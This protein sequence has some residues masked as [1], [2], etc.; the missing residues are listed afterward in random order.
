MSD[1]LN[2]YHREPAMEGIGPYLRYGL[3][4]QGCH[5]NCEGCMFLENYD[6]HRENY[7]SVDDLFEEIMS[8]KDIDGITVSGGE[9]LLQIPALTQLFKKVK[10]H[11][12]GVIVYTGYTR[13]EIH[14]LEGGEDILAYI[15]LL[16]AGPYMK[17]LNDDSPMKGSSNQKFFMFSD[18][19]Y[20][21]MLNLP[22]QRQAYLDLDQDP[23]MIL[24][25][26]S[27][28]EYLFFKDM[29][30]FQTYGDMEGWDE[31]SE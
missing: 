11:G 14:D 30:A 5:K 19:Y 27:V 29:I 28:R 25:I 15:D 6:V 26:P 23:M 12:L 24:G 13:A 31:N 22:K 21:E 17:D 2:V 7:I 3:W 9:P 16:I 1:V 18:Y 20:Q 8:E 10:D 4:L